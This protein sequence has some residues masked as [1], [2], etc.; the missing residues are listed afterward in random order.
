MKAMTDARVQPRDVDE[1]VLVGG[2]TRM[3]SV[4]ALVKRV[5]DKR[6]EQERQS[7]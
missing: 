7:G 2:Q 1:V 4:V 5:F 3:P 6:A